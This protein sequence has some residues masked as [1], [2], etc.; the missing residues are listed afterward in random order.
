MLVEKGSDDGSVLCRAVECPVPSTALIKSY[1]MLVG[2]WLAAG[3]LVAL[4]SLGRQGVVSEFR[5][6]SVI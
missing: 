4:H 2:S 3:L 5:G 6:Y 1:G